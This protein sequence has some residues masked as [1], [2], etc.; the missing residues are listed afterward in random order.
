MRG[1]RRLRRTALLS[2]LTLVVGVMVT[3]VSQAHPDH[4]GSGGREDF[5][6]EGVADGMYKQHDGTEGHLPPVNNNVTLVGRAEVT[7]P[8]GTGNTGRVADVTAFGD[9]AYLNAFRE[10][11]CGQTGVHVVDISDPAHPAEVLDAFIPTSAGSYAGE[12]IQVMHV[13]NAYFSGDLLAHQNETCPGAAPAPPNS[14]GISLWDV[15]DPRHPQPV[16]LHTGDF[17]NPGGGLDPAPNQTHS[18]RMWTN[19]FDGKT[20]VVLVDD[21]EQADVDIM[22][23]TDPFHPVMVN[24]TLDLDVLFGVDQA[25]PTNLTSVFSH[26][27]MITKIGQRYVMNMNYWDG[28][29]VLLDVTDPGPGKV[30]LI[31]ESDYAALD[32]QRLAR[33]HSISPEGNSHQSELS[34]NKKF[35]LGTDEDFNPFRVI[36]TI[37]SGPYA[38][39]SYIATQ[40]SDTPPIDQDTEISGPTTYVG[41]ACAALP[42]GSGTALVERGTCTFQAKL[43]NITAAGY[44]AGIVFQ[45]VRADCLAGVTMLASGGIPYVFV[46]RLRGLQLLGIAGVTEAN[47]CTTPSPAAG[48]PS[49]TTTIRAVFDG[50]GYVRLFGT[51]ISPKVGVPGSITQIDT[52]SVPEAQDPAY[53]IGFGDLS[54]HE[55][56][57]DPDNSE[58][59]Y[60]SY[61][62][63]GF[64]VVKYG[65]T[66]IQEVGAFID[67]GGNNFWGVE[68]WKDETGQKYILGSDRDF[69]LYIF[70][71]TG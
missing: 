18:M 65:K 32:E 43:N 62:A 19:N 13:D 37:D 15:T 38:G 35:L 45:N 20:Y 21:E 33:G 63:A 28:G 2:S 5:P 17:T 7:N 71:F 23:I 1:Q 4:P 49:A 53:A 46:N 27:M 14:G 40:A 9:Y 34:P 48:S 47:A 66:G 54:V 30:T 51:E 3:G 39:T 16:A 42:A 44:T 6:G 10:P 58:I 68:V 29:Y 36:A 50:W 52:Y 57:M 64:R 56:A 55:V 11:T 12:G 69:G 22:D 31:A 70:R 24:D 26:D 60:I 61:Y 8:A 59:A 67:Q 41:N 25:T